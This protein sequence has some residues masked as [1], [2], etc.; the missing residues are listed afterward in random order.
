MVLI[1][2]YVLKKNHLKR[3]TQAFEEK[4]QTENKR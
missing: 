2:I 1:I 3:D 4:A